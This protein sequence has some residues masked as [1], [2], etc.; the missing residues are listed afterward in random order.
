MKEVSEITSPLIERKVRVLNT[1][2]KKVSTGSGQDYIQIGRDRHKKGNS[3]SNTILSQNTLAMSNMAG[4]NTDCTHNT[5]G[6]ETT[7]KLSSL[8]NEN[9]YSVISFDGLGPHMNSKGN[10]TNHKNSKLS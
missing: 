5:L 7:D 3:F 10:K 4:E 6:Y 9:T 1:N 2:K 8:R